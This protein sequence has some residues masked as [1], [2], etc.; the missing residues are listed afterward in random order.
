MVI[1]TYR[2]MVSIMVSRQPTYLVK[3]LSYDIS[4]QISTLGMLILI[5]DCLLEVVKK[6]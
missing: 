6:C 1:T 5:V 4:T 3:W 2:A